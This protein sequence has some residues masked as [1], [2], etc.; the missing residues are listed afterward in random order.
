MVTND[1]PHWFPDHRESERRLRP[2][3]R[4]G[5]DRRY[6][7]MTAAVERRGAG[8]RRVLADR[9]SSTERR[10]ERRHDVTAE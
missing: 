3:R 9:R 5:L 10:P 7:D 8:E 1:A 2:S 6:Q 4:S